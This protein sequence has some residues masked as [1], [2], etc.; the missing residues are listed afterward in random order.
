MEQDE[1]PAAVAAAGV[2]RRSAGYLLLTVDAPAEAREAVAAL[3]HELPT[4]GVIEEEG[5]AGLVR[6]RA[7]LRAEAA[8][9]PQAQGAGGGLDELCRRLAALPSFGLGAIP[10]TLSLKEAAEEPWA[11]SWREHYHA[12]P[13]GRRL[14]VV[15]TWERPDLPADAV[16]IRLDPGMAFGSGL[17]SSTQLCLQLLEEYLQPGWSVADVGTGSGILAV[18]AAKLGAARVLAVDHDPLAV[19]VARSN[20]AHNHVQQTV[21]VVLGDLLAPLDVPV[22]LILANLTASAVISLTPEIVPRLR[23]GGRA[24][25]SGIT[26]LREADV[27]QALG[28]AGLRPLQVAAA[29][30]WRAFLAAVAEP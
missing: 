25:L 21:E 4:G 19:E 12:F 30:E 23:P 10:P 11:T 1:G 2:G 26:D 18:A 29:G 8:G 5:T 27:R 20:V 24:I 15:P 3:L 17:H 13:V 22:D 14:W 7:Y 16:P 9:G 28:G 6:L